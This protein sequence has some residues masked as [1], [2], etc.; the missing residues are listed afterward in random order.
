MEMFEGME[1]DSIMSMPTT[2]RFRLI[3]KK[4]NLERRRADQQR[5]EASRARMRRR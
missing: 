5:N 2:R 1:Y 3:L 4:G